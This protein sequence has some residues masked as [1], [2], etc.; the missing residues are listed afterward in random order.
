MKTIK[1]FSSALLISGLLVSTAFASDGDKAKS[2][3]QASENSVRE[4]LTSALSDIAS[5]TD[6]IVFIKFSVSSEKGFQLLDV[7]GDNSALNEQVVS[8]L[9]RETVEVP[10]E[11]KGNY[12]V[13]VLFTDKYA[14][15]APVKATD[16][17]RND[18]ADVL[19]KLNVNESA[20][21]KLVLL[22]KNNTIKVS[23]IEGASKYLASTIES[24][25]N[26]SKINV[27]SDL[28]GKYELNVQF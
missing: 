25:L 15:N 4:Q 23:N 8:L 21:V 12:V 28:A 17:L 3:K 24:S 22:V 1:F 26:A 7:T 5:N 10:S 6:G 14:V 20:S 2:E 18:V 13:K 9:K 16:A 27:P 11:M 19:S